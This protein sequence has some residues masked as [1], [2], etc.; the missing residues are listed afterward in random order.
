MSAKRPA[1]ESRYERVDECHRLLFVPWHEMTVE[2][3][4]RLDRRVD[5]VPAQ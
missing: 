2:V 4:G 3:E 1:A 5:E